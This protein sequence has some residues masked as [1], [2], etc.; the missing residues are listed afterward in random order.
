M[1]IDAHHHL[2]RLSRGDYGWLTP[3]LA[4]IH[5]DFAPGDLEPLLAAAGITRTVIVQAAPTLAETLF[6]LDIAA[7]TDWVAGVVGW[8]DMEAPDAI[9]QLDRL[10]AYPKFRGIRPM[11]QDI[12]ADD[13][14][15]RPA[16]D[17]VFQTLIERQLTFDAL[18]LPRH[19]PHLLTR[20]RQFPGLACVIDH[21]AKPL[22]ATGD[23]A[24]W[25]R[26]IARIA[27]ETGAFCK[28]SGLLTEAG[29][30]PTLEKVR[31]AAEHI[32]SAFGP[33]RVMFGSDWPVLNLAGCYAGWVAMV[34]NLL[35]PLPETARQ[36]VW[37]GN[38]AAFYG[39]P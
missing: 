34:E 36:A 1:R 14:I 10:Q 29:E 6:L 32:I 35:S 26:D 11:I 20:L 7:S 22:L 15:L 25:K 16:L 12:A 38:A 3:D 8:I 39:L 28:L 37:G 18:V 2:W 5:R 13:W 9:Q 30:A 4:P 19:L 17:Q 21:G 31:P 33:N 27:G 23:I 24:T